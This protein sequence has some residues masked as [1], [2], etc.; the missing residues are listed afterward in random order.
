MKIILYTSETHYFVQVNSEPYIHTVINYT[1]KQLTKKYNGNWTYTIK[2]TNVKKA[3]AQAKKI[4]IIKSVSKATNLKYAN[5][6]VAYVFANYNKK[7][8]VYELYNTVTNNY[9]IGVTK[10]VVNRMNLHKSRSEEHT[11]ELQS[12]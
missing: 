5:N 2:H 10:N 8:V 1:L 12:H 4:A 9:Y 7:Y 3:N 11:S 6:R